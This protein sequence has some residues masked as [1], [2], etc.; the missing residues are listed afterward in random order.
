[1]A[2]CICSTVFP[3]H[4]FNFVP[5]LDYDLKTYLNL[6]SRFGNELKQV[7]NPNPTDTKVLPW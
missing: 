4:S 1:M 2:L 7:V 6:N 5:S 3:I